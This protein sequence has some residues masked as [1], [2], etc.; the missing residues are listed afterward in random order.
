MAHDKKKQSTGSW[1]GN[2][3]KHQQSK[4]HG[5]GQKPT[6]HSP[7]YVKDKYKK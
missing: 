3:D 6:K 7:G 1:K 5:P 2:R 4:P